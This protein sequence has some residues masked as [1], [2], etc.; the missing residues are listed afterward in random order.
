MVKVKVACVQM[1]A[2]PNIDENL[3]QAEGLIREAVAKGAQF[4]FT[5]ENTDYMR[6]TA[7]QTVETAPTES[8]HPAIPFF[9]ELAKELKIHLLIGSLKIKLE[10]IKEE[11]IANRSL[12]FSPDGAELAR[13]DKIHLYDVDLQNGEKYRESDSMQGGDKAIMVDTPFGKT[14]VTIC[15]D[16]RFPHLYR[17][18]AK[19]GAMIL[20]IPAAFTAH[21][22][23]AHWETLLRARAIENGCFVIAAAQAGLH[24]GGRSTHAHSMIINPWGEILAE[25]TEDNIGVI[26]HEINLDDVM[27]AR[28]AVPSLNNDK[29]YTIKEF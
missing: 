3:K 2:G 18:L 27:T 9:S 28:N 15:Y 17:E 22:G 19:Q 7:A 11:K 16:V 4:I 12:F 5:P 21:T 25:H 13:Y 8:E 14:G 29:E 26:V 23:K 24:E 6:G 1:N 10:Q 20:S